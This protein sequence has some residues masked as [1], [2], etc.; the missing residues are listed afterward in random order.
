MLVTLCIDSSEWLQTSRNCLLGSR[1][2]DK[3]VTCYVHNLSHRHC[4]EFPST[5][6]NFDLNT[7]SGQFPHC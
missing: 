4:P 2:L 1:I 5:L 3:L 6:V 7:D